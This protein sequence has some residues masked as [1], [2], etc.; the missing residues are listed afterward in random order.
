MQ[1]SGRNTCV[2]SLCSNLCT[3]FGTTGLVSSVSRALS[4]KLRGPG[5]K[6]RPSTVAFPVTII[7]WGC[8]YRLKTS[9]ELN[10][11]TEAEGKTTGRC[12]QNNLTSYCSHMDRSGRATSE[13]GSDWQDLYYHPVCNRINNTHVQ[14]A[15]QSKAS[16]AHSCHIILI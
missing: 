3:T 4:S 10:P 7:M 5:F 6:C 8:S 16:H 9:F 2:I 13:V 15:Q 1:Y 12:Q 14:E 11:V